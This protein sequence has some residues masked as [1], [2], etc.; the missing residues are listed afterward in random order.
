MEEQEIKN[1]PI[2]AVVAEQ[3]RKS[4]AELVS[5]IENHLSALLGMDVN[6]AFEKVAS[7]QQIRGGA[8]NID[9]AHKSALVLIAHALSLITSQSKN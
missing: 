3:L 4:K 1:D 2:L 8:M 7:T 9:R 5:D 6:Q